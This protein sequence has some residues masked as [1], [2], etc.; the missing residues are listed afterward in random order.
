MMSPSTGHWYGGK[1]R[2]IGHEIRRP[3]SGAGQ[4]VMALIQ[5]VGEIEV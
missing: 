5:L 1:Q 3:Q 4:A 2:K